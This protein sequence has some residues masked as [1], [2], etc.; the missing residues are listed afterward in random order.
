MKNKIIKIR[1]TAEQIKEVME[2]F[3]FEEKDRTELEKT[4]RLLE[5]TAVPMFCYLKE[6]EIELPQYQDYVFCCALLG[7]AVDELIESIEE[8]N[9]L[10]E[11]YMLECLSMKMLEVLYEKGRCEIEKEGTFVVQYDFLEE[12]EEIISG[13]ASLKEFPVK[14]REGY[15][16]PQKSVIYA[17]VLSCEKKNTKPCSICESCGNKN[18]AKGHFKR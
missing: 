18:C 15:L 2:E 3:R 11:A 8:K 17:A 12:K 16:I 9:E 7:E 1:L 14:Y 13:L 6:K 10:L 5:E 4:A